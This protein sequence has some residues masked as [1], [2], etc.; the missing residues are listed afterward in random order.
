MQDAG[1]TAVP[2]TTGA[3]GKMNRRL[4]NQGRQIVTPSGEVRDKSTHSINPTL[5]LKQIL[6]REYRPL[7]RQT[8]DQVSRFAK[9]SA[10]LPHRTN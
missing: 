10:L 8:R 1:A 4:S 5:H 2:E 7:R 6:G 9:P 3:G